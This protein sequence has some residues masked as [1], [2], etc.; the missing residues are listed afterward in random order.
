MPCRDHH[1]FEVRLELGL[2][3][4]ELRPLVARLEAVA[5]EVIADIDPRAGI[6]ELV[7]LSV[8]PGVPD[9]PPVDLGGLVQVHRQP[10]RPAGCR[11]PLRELGSVDGAGRA[12]VGE[13]GRARRGGLSKGQAPLVVE[14]EDAA[15][16]VPISQL[17]QLIVP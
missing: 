11:D 5:V 3:R 4:E 7:G 9:D 15:R 12:L 13:R 14:A 8:D 2:L 10:I 16:K 6:R 17:P 1:T